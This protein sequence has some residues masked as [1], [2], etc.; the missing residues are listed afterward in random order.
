VI[1]R[2]ASLNGGR[3]NTGGDVCVDSWRDLPAAAESLQFLE[4]VHCPIELA[5]DHAVVSHYISQT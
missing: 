4:L 1:N 2:L 5:A 3:R